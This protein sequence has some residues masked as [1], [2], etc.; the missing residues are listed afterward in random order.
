MTRVTLLM[1]AAFL[2]ASTC[3]AQTPDHFDSSEPQMVNQMECVFDASR[4]L[5]VMSPKPT[6]PSDWIISTDADGT[7]YVNNQRLIKEPDND[8][9]IKDGGG[10]VMAKN[11]ALVGSVTESGAQNNPEMIQAM[12]IMLQGTMDSRPYP[13]YVSVD[14]NKQH[15]VFSDWDKSKKAYAPGGYKVDCYS[16]TK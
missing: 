5:G 16:D 11:F 6:P 10:F 9:P 13:R 1:A 15:L 14:F 12:M 7:L 8:P 3:F 2:S 4:M